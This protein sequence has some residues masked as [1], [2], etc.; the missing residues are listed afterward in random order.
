MDRTPRS[1]WNKNRSNWRATTIIFRDEEFVTNSC[2]RYWKYKYKD[3]VQVVVFLI[4]WLKI[5]KKF[6][7]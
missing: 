2:E 6:I 7:N 1:F 5:K 3:D 4:N